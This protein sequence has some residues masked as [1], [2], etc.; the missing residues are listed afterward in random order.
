VKKNG[1]K[2]TYIKK[3]KILFKNLWQDFHEYIYFNQ[4]KYYYYFYSNKAQKHQQQ[5]QQQN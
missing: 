3:N 2:Y 1:K 5:Q 4:L